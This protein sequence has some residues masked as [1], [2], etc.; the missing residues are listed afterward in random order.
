MYITIRFAAGRIRKG[1][2]PLNL[3]IPP[4]ELNEAEEK[5]VIC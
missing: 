5:P 2:T 4:Y 1:P 3:E